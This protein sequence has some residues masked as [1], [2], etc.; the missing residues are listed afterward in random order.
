MSQLA[1]ILGFATQKI[2]NRHIFRS[3]LTTKTVQKSHLKNSQIEIVILKLILCN[4]P[5]L[6]F[7]ESFIDR[8]FLNEKSAEV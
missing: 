2:T 4:F 7:S 1:L 5:L 8:G 3:I 6:P